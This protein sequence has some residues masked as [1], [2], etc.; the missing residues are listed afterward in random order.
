MLARRACARR[1]CARRAGARRALALLTTL[2][3]LTSACDGPTAPSGPPTDSSLVAFRFTPAANPALTAE[4]AGVIDGDTIRVILPR[5]M[6]VTS[7]AATFS[8]ST[9]GATLRVSG[10]TQ[11]SGSSRVNFTLP[12][13]YELAS[14]SG[15]VR[16][17]IVD[18]TVFT[19]LP[20]VSITTEGGAPILTREDYV[21]AVIEVFGGKERPEHT[22]SATT[23]IR[24]R[25]NSTWSNPKKPYRL[26]LTTASSLFGFPADRDWTLLAN[27]WDQSLVRTALA[28]ELSRLVGMPY[29]PRC[30]AVEFVLNGQHQGSYQLC[31][32][33]EVAAQR[34]PATTGWLLAIDDLPRLEPTDV[35]FHSP[36]LDAWSMESD[37]NPSVW[38]YKQP[39]APTATQRAAIE[40]ELLGFEALLY[41]E[42][43]AHPDTGYAK[44]LDVDAAIGWYL[45]QEL[46]KNSDAAFFKSV[47]VYKAPQGRITI[48]PVWDFDLAG[49]NYPYD[50]GPTGWKIRNSAWIARLFED[51]AFIDRIKLRWRALYAQ[52]AEVDAFIV[53]YA[54]RLRLSEGPNHALWFPYGPLPLLQAGDLTADLR[55]APV[56][57][58]RTSEGAL[59]DYAGQVGT[60]R[61][62]MNARWSWLNAGIL[63]L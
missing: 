2:A 11:R 30:T 12:V 41:G 56:V 15:S 54:A 48:G 32:H 42:G 46:L 1:A 8:F 39:D 53:T 17:Y 23:E 10:A 29:T 18:V 61:A 47:F 52:R 35:V 14:S 34:I 58:T 33:M 28:F 4:V 5:A 19:G 6:S 55:A 60:L 40:A 9:P 13:R 63:D 49:G 62:W 57:R 51:R 21:R 20:I 27:Y 26:K 37:P 7:L 22:I 38:V 31:E 24:G 59:V 50:A 36:R 25:G 16:A 3:A 44:D 45:V 43:F